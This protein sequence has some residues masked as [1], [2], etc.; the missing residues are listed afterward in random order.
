M[1]ARYYDPVIGRFY[2]N[3]PVGFTGDITT[4]NRYSYVGNNPYKYVDPDGMERTKAAGLMGILKMVLP[5][6]HRGNVDKWTRGARIADLIERGNY[7]AAEKLL[8]QDVSKK[9]RS[10]SRF[11]QE[12]GELK[13][14][15]DK[16]QYCGQNDASQVDHMETVSDFADS[17]IDGNLTVGEAEEL[18]NNSANFADS[19]GGSTGSCNQQKGKKSASEFGGENSSDRVKRRRRNK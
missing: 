7:K 2:S 15:G 11:K 17:V 14:R 9:I 1:Q 6:K 16:C 18:A 10:S 5:K 12:K 13:Q 4:F 3:D 19:C 8:K